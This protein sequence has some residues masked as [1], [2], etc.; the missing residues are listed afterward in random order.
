MRTF[1]QYFT[2]FFCLF[3]CLWSYP[4]LLPIALYKVNLKCEACNY[5][6]V[7]TLKISIQK[8]KTLREKTK[9]RE[10]EIL[11][12]AQRVRHVPLYYRRIQFLKNIPWLVDHSGF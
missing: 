1:A 6:D 2:W 5:I 12:L 4:N 11:L 7:G 3:I 8:K 10:I 9:I